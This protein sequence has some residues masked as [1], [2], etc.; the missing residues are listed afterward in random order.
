EMI[1]TQASGQLKHGRTGA[2]VA[3][4]T[5]TGTPL[6]LGPEA[7]PREALARWMIEPGNPYFAKVM[8]NRVW[9]EIMG[10][11]IVDPND[12]FRATNPA[13]N[14]PLLAYLADEFRREGFD[15]KK[16][17]KKIMTSEVFGLS[18]TPSARNVS[19]LRNFSRYYRERMRAEVLLDAV[20]DVL[21]TD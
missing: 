15:I 16:L 5:L 9:G 4:K 17:I 6:A 1:F 10:V 7:D 13:S 3:P 20:N 19:D 21:G 11:A 8:A 18:S 2:A 12:D 14:E